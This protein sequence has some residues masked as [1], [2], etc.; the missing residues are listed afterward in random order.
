MTQS[1]QMTLYD[2]LE[3]VFGQ[4]PTPAPTGRAV[5]L[6][7]ENFFVG[8]T[9]ADSPEL[10]AG[11]EPEDQT[12]NG[13]EGGGELQVALSPRNYDHYLAA[14]LWAEWGEP[15]GTASTPVRTGG[16]A[17]VTYTPDGANPRRLTTSGS[18][19]NTPNVGDK[20]LVQ[21][22]TNAYLNGIHRV[23]AA[24][25]STCDL[26]E[27]GILSDPVKV[28]AIAVA[29]DITIMRCQRLTNSLTPALQSIGFEKRIQRTRGTHLGVTASP[30]S[31]TTDYSVFYAGVPT[32][33]QFQGTADSPITGSFSFSMG[34]QTDSSQAGGGA[35]VLGGTSAYD[36][37]PIFQGVQCLKKVRFY[38]PAMSGTA[39]DAGII[40]DTLRLCP[41]SVSCEIGN[42][43]NVSPLMCAEPEKDYEFGEPL[44]SWQVTGIYENPFAKVAFNQQLEGVFEVAMVAT[45]GEGYLF[46]MPRAKVQVAR[47]D[48]PGRRQILA[49]QMTVKA[50]R[51]NSP[52]T[53]D[54]ARAVEI[55]RFRRSTGGGSWP[56]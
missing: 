25:S 45:N 4:L 8:P 54:S 5:R 56:W 19:T 35:T 3:T 11:N 52:L 20:V 13:Y 38:V 2:W 23:I 33:F 36:S 6:I 1:G 42:N 26:E 28:P 7:S 31:T 40:E 18:W 22:S 53:G 50:F 10:T 43:M 12:L 37:T 32:R 39:G 9:L 47:V 29:Q 49:A 44:M 48:T 30:G 24:T 21:G 14:L 16:T 55:Y 27:D 41:Q 46:R 15:A 51:Q 34:R 17:A